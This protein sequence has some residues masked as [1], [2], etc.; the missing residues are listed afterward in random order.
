MRSWSALVLPALCGLLTFQALV[1]QGAAEDE[2]GSSVKFAW[3]PSQKCVDTFDGPINCAMCDEKDLWCLTCLPNFGFNG[4]GRCQRCED[5]LCGFCT[6]APGSPTRMTVCQT[7]RGTN[8]LDFPS[9]AFNPPGFPTF[10]DAQGRCRRCVNQEENTGCLSCDMAGNT[11]TKCNDG[12]F[13]DRFGQCA[14][15]EGNNCIECGSSLK[16][17]ECLPVSFAPGF[18]LNPAG[19]CQACQN[20]GCAQC[21]DNFRDCAICQDGFPNS[22][23]RGFGQSGNGQ[24]KPCA[25]KNCALCQ[26]DYRVCEACFSDGFDNTWFYL[27]T[28]DQCKECTLPGCKTCDSSGDK[29]LECKE[30]FALNR[31]KCEALPKCRDANC[32]DCRGDTKSCTA[33]KERFFLSNGM[34]L[35]CI[36]RCAECS[37]PGTTQ[38]KRCVI[39]WGLDRSTK[40]CLRCTNKNEG[41]S[42][43]SACNGDVSRCTQCWPQEIFRPDGNGNCVR[44]RD[45]EPQLPPPTMYYK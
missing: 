35:P 3:G 9:S 11:C 4:N 7:C 34:C 10:M 20:Q 15:C 19:T 8:T 41:Y 27:T 21:N 31:G 22:G 42:W 5:P 30:G 25:D 44:Y 6:F 45:P 13:R 28:G 39:N 16:C 26:N 43:C 24:C 36:G 33:C 18:G 2:I 12:Y 37:G 40:T 32:F 17:R 38:C 14:P 29:C 1:Q 23:V